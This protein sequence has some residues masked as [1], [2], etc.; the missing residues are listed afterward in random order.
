M[1]LII[2]L[3]KQIATMYILMFVGYFAYKGKLIS[4]AGAKDFSNILVKIVLPI[5]ILNSFAIEKTVDTDKELLHSA[6][7]SLI[8]MA[9]SIAVS[10]LIYHQKD[11]IAEF[12][13]EFSN[14]GF[15][16]IPLIQAVLGNY[17]VFQ[18]SM[19]IVL[20]GILQWTYGSYIISQDRSVIT[21]KKILRNP[22]IIGVLLGFLIYLFGIRIPPFVGNLISYISGLNTP[23]AMMV[24]GVYLAQSDLVTTFRSR[25]AYVVSSIRLVLIPLLTLAVFRFLPVGSTELKLAVLLASSCPVGSNSVI[26]AGMYGKDFK[27]AVSEVC[28][29][30]ILCI[31]T[32]PLIT[33]LATL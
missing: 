31:L 2:I 25:K 7:I 24:T 28:V 1:E 14:A 29:S 20:I 21:Y 13:A 11:T 4:D 10:F 8:S 22:V 12:S 26:I 32:L 30:T 33:F 9:L 18:I 16:G 23:L 6:L 27:S 5:V 19:M 3:L 15:I 17:A